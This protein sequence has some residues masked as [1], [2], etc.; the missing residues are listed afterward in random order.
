M[1]FAVAIEPAGRGGRIKADAGVFSAPDLPAGDYIVR[2]DDMPDRCRVKGGVE[3]KI[4]VSPRR[5]AS[6]RFDVICN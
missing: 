3:R 4:S 2:L 1:E 6:V 5:S